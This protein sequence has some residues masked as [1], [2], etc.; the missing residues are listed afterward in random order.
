M[1]A[2]PARP[3]D[4]ATRLFPT[5]SRLRSRRQSP[6]LTARLRNQ[7][8]KCMRVHTQN[9]K[10]TQKGKPTQNGQTKSKKTRRGRQ[11]AEPTKNTNKKQHQANQPEQPNQGANTAV[12]TNTYGRA[13]IFS[14]G[15]AVS[16]TRQGQAQ[17][18]KRLSPFMP[19]K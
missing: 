5:L 10:P 17:R 13:F 8:C 14:E 11:T 3:W 18:R 6:R 4:G 2:C 12:M 1:I 16:Y 9:G 15:A 7:V 19:H